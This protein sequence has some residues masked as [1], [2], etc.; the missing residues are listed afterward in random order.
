[1]PF[2]IDFINIE[3]FIEQ[4]NVSTKVDEDWKTFLNENKEKDIEKLIKEENLKQEETIKFIENAFRDGVLK[5]TGTDIDNIMP[6][7][8]RFA[9]NSRIAKKETIIEKLLAFFLKNTLAWCK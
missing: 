4:V 8:S 1:M 7:V 6:P 9:S 2:R 3:R 5:T